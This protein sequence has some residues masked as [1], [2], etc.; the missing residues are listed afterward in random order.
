[1]AHG[2]YPAAYSRIVYD[3][4]V[5]AWRLILGLSAR[6]IATTGLAS[7]YYRIHLKEA[8]EIYMVFINRPY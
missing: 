1:M 2:V 6:C 4:D 8:P 3:A 7:S 5:G